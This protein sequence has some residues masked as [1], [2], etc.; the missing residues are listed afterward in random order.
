MVFFS[1]FFLGYTPGSTAF[2]LIR[3][4]CLRPIFQSTKATQLQNNHNGNAK[5]F[6]KH[7]ASVQK[8]RRPPSSSP[9]RVRQQPRARQLRVRLLGGN[10]GP[11]NLLPSAP[12]LCVCRRHLCVRLSPPLRFPER[13]LFLHDRR[14]RFAKLMVAQISMAV[15]QNL[16]IAPDG[17]KRG[18]MQ[19]SIVHTLA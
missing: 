6:Q 1:A 19:T 2:R 10:P 12:S 7:G 9:K 8:I 14:G 15:Q 5:N 18:Y 4:R 17:R 3:Q 11:T 13:P 16:E